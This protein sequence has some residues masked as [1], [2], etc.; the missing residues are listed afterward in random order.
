MLTNMVTEELVASGVHLVQHSQVGSS[1][2][3]A[4]GDCRQSLLVSPPV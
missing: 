4:A 1:T 3:E 2:H